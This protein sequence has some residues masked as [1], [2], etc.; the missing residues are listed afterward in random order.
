QSACAARPVLLRIC[1]AARLASFSREGQPRPTQSVE[2]DLYLVVDDA[3]RVSLQILGRRRVQ[4]LAAADVKTRG[5]QRALDHLAVEPA[6]GQAGIG[7][8][9]NIIGC[10]EVAV[11]GVEGDRMASNL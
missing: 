2:A 9:A 5:M 7:V 11:G 1:S 8:S 4:H 3:H 10:K 6:V